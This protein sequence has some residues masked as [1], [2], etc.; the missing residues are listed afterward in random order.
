MSDTTQ[1]SESVLPTETEAPK[2]ETT[3]TVETK[4]SADGKDQTKEGETLLTE[5]KDEK[6]PTGAPE[7]YEAFKLP[8][9]F[10]MTEAQTT[11]VQKL[12]KEQGFTQ[13]QAQAM[14]DYYA[15]MSQS[16]MK[17]QRDAY[18]TQRKEWKDAVLA[19]PEMKDFNSVRTGI[20]RMIDGLGDAAL[21]KEF[22]QAMDLTGAGDHPAFVKLFHKLATKYSEGKPATGGVPNVTRPGTAE[23]PS[24]AH[25]LYPNLT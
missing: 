2:V 12:F 25:A 23:R 16:A 22:R 15:S 4:P 13:A 17:E 8:E 19:D 6:A 20:G 3:S 10:V 7:K 24:A 9:N 1:A 11:D 5:K 21:A 14:V 18:T